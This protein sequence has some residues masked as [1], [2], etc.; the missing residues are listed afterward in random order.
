MRERGT[1]FHGVTSHRDSTYVSGKLDFPD[2]HPML[3]HFRFLK[4]HSAVT[5]KMCIPSPSV[6]HFRRGREGVSREAYP[7]MAGYFID[8]AKC[9][10]KAMRALYD[11]GCRYLQIDDMV[12]AI[13]ATQQRAMARDRG[14][15]PRQASGIYARMINH[16]IA[17]SRPT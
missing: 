1:F 8:L 10:R 4:A 16:A 13:C 12:C 5:P 9:Y 14:E 2:D 3:E 17:T 15:D 11:A 6:L 7:D